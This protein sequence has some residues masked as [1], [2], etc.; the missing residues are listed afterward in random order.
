MKKAPLFW[1]ILISAVFFTVLGVL[2]Y[3]NIYAAEEASFSDSPMLTRV[4]SAINNDVYPWDIF[5]REKVLSAKAQALKT[6]EKEEA[7]KAKAEDAFAADAALKTE[8]AADAASQTEE[9]VMSD[10]ESGTGEGLASPTPIATPHAT[11]TPTP[12]PKASPTPTPTPSFEARYAPLRESTYDEY[13]NHVSA[14]IYGMDGV[15]HAALYEFSQVDES[16]FDD[17]LFIGDSRTVGLKKYTDLAEHADFLCV[18]SMTI[19]KALSADFSGQGSIEDSLMNK[20]YG[21]IYLMLGVNE[22]GTGTTEDYIASYTEVVD[23]IHELAPNAV[24]FMQAIM[25]IDKERSD[26]DKVFNNANILG[27]N[28]AIASL[29]D[30]ETFFYIDVN[31]VVCDE[32]GY[33]R[34]DLRGDHLHLKGASNQLWK[35]FL[36]SHGVK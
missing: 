36:L 5:N 1:A 29:A 22:L 6:K 4:F 23:R 25:G 18:T 17:A 31:S 7:M 24:I 14:D 16:Y 12:T 33:L 34:D 10:T 3:G 32:E 13:I 20:E 19:Y 11:A 27:R 28:H 35:D 15:E 8:D 9:A 21:K 2:G 30:N 26:S